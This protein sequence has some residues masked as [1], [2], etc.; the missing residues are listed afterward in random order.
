MFQHSFVFFWNHW[1]FRTTVL[2]EMAWFIIQIKFLDFFDNLSF[3]WKSFFASL[4][5]LHF[6]WIWFHVIGIVAVEMLFFIIKT[7]DGFHI[8]IHFI[9]RVSM[10]IFMIIYK[11]FYFFTDMLIIW[12]ENFNLC[13][14]LNLNCVISF[15]NSSLFESL[16]IL[17]IWCFFSEL[18]FS[19]S[20]FFSNLTSFLILIFFFDFGF[21]VSDLVFF[22]IK[23]SL[24]FIIWILSL[25][26]QYKIKIK[27]KTN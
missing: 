1:I 24:N 2:R 18:A 21:S 8:D 5:W 11:M 15:I 4:R 25:V 19:N 6:H 20:I 17:Q 13:I 16:L 10:T 14:F 23:T 9:T 7:F 3:F 26:L 27:P 22:Y 12:M